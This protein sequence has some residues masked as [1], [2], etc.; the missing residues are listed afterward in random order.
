MSL[1][2]TKNMTTDTDIFLNLLADESK[3]K[4]QPIQKMTVL[5]ENTSEDD[6][7]VDAINLEGK[8]QSNLKFQQTDKQESPVRDSCK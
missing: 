8:S 2:P 3:I 4:D 7:V 6:Y 5:N 1:K